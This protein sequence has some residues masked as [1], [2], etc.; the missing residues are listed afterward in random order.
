MDKLT[1]KEQVMSQSLL[2]E[3]TENI[4]MDIREPFLKQIK[5]VSQNRLKMIE[6]LMRE[7][8]K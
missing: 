2:G 3:F 1:A 6:R 8:Q 4:D 7:D 5:K